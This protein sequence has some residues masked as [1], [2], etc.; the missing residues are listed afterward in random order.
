MDIRSTFGSYLK[1]S[2]VA[3]RPARLTIKNC[4][5]EKV[6]QESSQEMKA[7]LYFEGTEKGLVLNKINSTTI[8][9]AYGFETNSW[10]GCRIELYHDFTEFAGKRVECI[11]VRTPSIQVSAPAPPQAPMQQHG[12]PA[13]YQ[14]PQVT[15]QHDE[16]S[17]PF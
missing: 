1:A 3:D 8:G 4:V 11:R 10:S 2:D 17:I 7:V 12:P 5:M 13:D 15:G 9:D 6:G 14:S 16:D